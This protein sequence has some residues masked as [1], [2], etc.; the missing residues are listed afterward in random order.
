M[1]MGPDQEEF[2][3]ESEKLIQLIGKLLLVHCRLEAHQ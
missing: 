3:V 1:G 2:L